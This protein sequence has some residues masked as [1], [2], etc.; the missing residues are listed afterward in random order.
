MPAALA[1]NETLGRLIRTGGWAELAK[2]T[3]RLIERAWAAQDTATAQALI[4]F[5]GA[6]MRVVHDIYEQWFRDTRRYLTDTGMAVADLDAAH[7]AIRDRLAPYHITVRQPRQQIWSEIEAALASAKEGALPE[8]A[9]SAA[10]AD[11]VGLWRDLHDGEVDQLSGLFH[12]VTSRKG[13]PALRE[14]YEGWVI[15]DWFAKRYQ[16]F[17]VSKIDWETASWLLVYLGFEGHHGHLSGTARDGS[18][19]YVEDAEKITL[20]FAP[21]GSGG[22]SMAGEAR[23]GMP[24]LGSPAIGWTELQER[25]DFTWNETGICAYCAHCCILHENLP[26]AAFGYP[27]RVTTPPKAP[28]TGESR[29]SWTVYKNLRDIP[30]AAYT[31]VGAVKPAADA[32]LGSA[33]RQARSAMAPNSD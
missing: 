25:H 27:V 16:R 23:D 20:S 17:D 6:E 29:C 31:R 8:A 10:L 3:P 13:E 28:L 1:H 2:G 14:M 9:R 12:L 22:R 32:P 7:A 21:C 24:A 18:I 33:G 5:F 26:I 4:D 30:E 11:A 19:D 15:G